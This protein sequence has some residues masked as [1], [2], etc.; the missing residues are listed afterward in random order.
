M[1]DKIWDMI[2]EIWSDTWERCD[3]WYDLKYDSYACCC[4][5]Q[6]IDGQQGKYISYN[7][8]GEIIEYC[9]VQA[10]CD[11]NPIEFKRDGAIVVNPLTIS[12]SKVRQLES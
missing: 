11:G 4:E 2:Y 9:A 12:A 10:P 3:T 8:G 5:S 6:E 7:E 1:K